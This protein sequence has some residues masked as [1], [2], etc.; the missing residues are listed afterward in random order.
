VD[1]SILDAGE[2]VLTDVHGTLVLLDSLINKMGP[3]PL[4]LF[5]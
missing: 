1:R 3:S 5:R 2:F 4:S